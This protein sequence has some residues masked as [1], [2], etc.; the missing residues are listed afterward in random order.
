MVKIKLKQN[1]KTTQK[2][3]LSLESKLFIKLIKLNIDEIND[4]LEK[5]L[6]ENPCLEEEPIRNVNEKN[7]LPEHEDLD[8]ETFTEYDENNIIDYLIKQINLLNISKKEKKIYACLVYLLDDKGFLCYSNEEIINILESQENINISLVDIEELILK[9]QRMLDPCGILARTT[10]ESLKIQLDMSNNKNF[11]L[12][13]NIIDNHLADIVKKDYKNISKSLNISISKVKKFTDDISELNANPANIFYSIDTNTKD[14]EPE[15]YVYIQNNKLIVQSNKNIKQV[16]VS[17]YYKKMLSLKSNLDSEVTE[18]L[19]E[20]ITNGTLLIKTINERE[21]MYSNVFK[22]L[23]EI[24]KD[25]ILK[26]ERYI[27]SLK[28]SDIAQ[29]LNVH[30]STISR[31]TSNKYISTPRG[32]LNMKRFF[33]NKINSSSE[34][35]S[36][37]VRDIIEELIGME[38]KK[39]PLTDDN[40]KSLLDQKGIAIARRTIAKYRNVLKIPS[41]NKRIKNK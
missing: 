12:Y 20:K 40:I 1:L 31:I 9:G 26:G 28:L 6:L 29:Q 18:Y 37:A 30:E 38:D 13:C 39:S 8:N 5:E 19:K 10:N 7:M 22:L 35:S 3:Y 16:R 41:S 33:V 17:N 27:K 15:A 34:K 2:G 14:P 24:Q 4:L 21:E 11:E 36:A 25:Y 23:V 32:M